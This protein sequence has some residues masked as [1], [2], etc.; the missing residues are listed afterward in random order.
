MIR[1]ENAS[2]RYLD[3]TNAVE[4]LSLEVRGPARPRLRGVDGAD[5]SHAAQ[6]WIAEHLA[7]HHG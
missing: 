6:A 3:G 1:F 4:K 2:V 7:H 5:P